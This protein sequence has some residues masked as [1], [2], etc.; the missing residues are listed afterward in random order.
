MR[1]LGKI[2]CKVSHG[3]LN[4]GNLLRL[5]MF[6]FKRNKRGFGNGKYIIIA[7]FF[8][9]IFRSVERGRREEELIKAILKEQE[10]KDNTLF[11]SVKEH[12]EHLGCTGNSS[13]NL[14]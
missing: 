7:I 4:L 1:R 10:D 3:Q 8:E 14:Q 12:L 2:I 13:L 5:N 6:P 11:H 9:K